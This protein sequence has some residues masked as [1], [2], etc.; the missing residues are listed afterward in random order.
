MLDI[1]P[2]APVI[3]PMSVEAIDKVREL[4]AMALDLPQVP[5]RTG[6]VLHAG[7][8]ARTIVIPAGVMLTGAL[9]KIPTVLIAEGEAMAYIGTD[10]PM[11][12]RGYSVIAAAAGRKQAF[13]ALSDLHLTMIF[14]TAAKTV[15]AAE[16][17]FTDEAE[18]LLSRREDK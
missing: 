7:L 6:H 8:Y 4:E 2:A 3:A 1:V 5:I 18:A 14:P 16:W 12:L 15:E 11:R 17:E 10:Q 13:L 9:V